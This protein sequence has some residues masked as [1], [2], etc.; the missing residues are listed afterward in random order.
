MG[1]IEL[2]SRFFKVWLYIFYNTTP[3]YHLPFLRQSSSPKRTA[4]GSA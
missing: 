2:P 3:A 1:P 4:T